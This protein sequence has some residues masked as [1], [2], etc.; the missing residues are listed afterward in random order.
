MELE[1]GGPEVV[2]KQAVSLDW[3]FSID[4]VAEI[5]RGQFGFRNG[6]GDG[7]SRGVD[8]GEFA[9]LKCDGDRKLKGDLSTRLRQRKR[10][11]RVGVLRRRRV[12]H[13]H[14]RWMR[15]GTGCLLTA[16]T[17]HGETDMHLPLPS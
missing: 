4:D 5:S 16:N 11:V 17:E 8:K 13:L 3:I 2:P 10:G 6:A 12:G 9:V 15:G 7:R 1:P 14:L